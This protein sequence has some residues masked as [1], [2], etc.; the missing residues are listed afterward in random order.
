[1]YVNGI[2][3]TTMNL[4]IVSPYPPSITGIG[5]Y[6]YH[7]SHL[8][9]K[10]GLFEHVSVL[11]S[12]SERNKVPPC[13]P[14]IDLRLVWQPESLTSS[15]KIISELQRLQPDLVWFNLGASIF[16]RSPL[17]N[18]A[19]FF[20]PLLT[21][22]MGFPTVV[23]LHEMVE[24]ADLQALKSPGGPLAPLGAHLLTQIALQADVICLTMQRY[25]DWLAKHYRDKRSIHIPIGA[26]HTPERLPSSPKQTREILFFTTLAPYKGLEILLEAFKS[27]RGEYPDLELT[28]AGAVHPRFPDYAEALKNATSQIIGIR[29]LGQV[30]ET[31]IRDL[32]QQSQI[33]CIPYTAST[34]SSSVLYQAAM[35]GRAII[36]SDLVETQTIARESNLQVS[37]FKNGSSAGLANALKK[38][39]DSPELQASQVARNIAAIQRT[40]PEETC[41]AYLRAFNLSLE[42]R[43]SPKRLFIPSQ[44]KQESA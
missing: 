18:L 24:L 16:G 6:G 39:L 12:Q 3:N 22:W 17:A 7:V 5:Q 34:G 32:F 14:G 38:L 30:P 33:V 10:S 43:G 25:V 15:L 8:L 23:T 35:W 41:Q 20:S 37:F 13:P 2:I 9:A 4:A 11:T 28:I 27:L 44:V 31:Q 1:M 36:A 42:T 19:G 21:R 29:W 26:Y 40:R